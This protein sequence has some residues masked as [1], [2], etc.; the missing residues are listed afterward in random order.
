MPLKFLKKDPAVDVGRFLHIIFSGSYWIFQTRA[1][2][3]IFPF[4]LETKKQIC[5][6]ETFIVHQQTDDALLKSVTN[7][8]VFCWVYTGRTAQEVPSWKYFRQTGCYWGT[9]SRGMTWFPDSALAFFYT[10]AGPW[11]PPH[12]DASWLRT[13]VQSNVSSFHLSHLQRTICSSK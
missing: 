3:P 10:R 11:L 4:E 6:C 2:K 7:L 13:R 5:G 9:C 12:C 1:L 8:S